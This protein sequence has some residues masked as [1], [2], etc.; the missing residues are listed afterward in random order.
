MS[1]T[2]YGDRT[3]LVHLAIESIARGS[4]RPA[5]IVLWLDERSAFDDPPRP[6]RRLQRR[7]LEI[8][9]S[10]NFGPHTKYFPF[11]ASSDRFD[12]PLVTADDDTIYPRSWLE[13]LVRA[14]SETPDSVI[15]YRAR[16]ILFRPDGSLAPYSEWDLSTGEG[17]TPLH[18]LTAV[19]GALHPPRLLRA[20]KERGRDFL[21]TCP[22]AD[23]VWIHHTA[24]RLGMGVRLVD[25]VS[26]TFPLIDGSQ[27]SALWYSNL[28]DGGNDTQLAQTFSAAD[29]ATLRAVSGSADAR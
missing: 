6:L 19:S 12:G 28:T 11:V 26:R 20:L 23:D 21:E 5:R 14:H 7:G 27:E 1:L 9:L 13:G 18:F 17:A 24:V 4:V 15:S 3:A 2:T 25:G 22:Q 10:E 29:I 8:R 16:T